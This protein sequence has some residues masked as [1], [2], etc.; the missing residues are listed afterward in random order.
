M[1][2]D[3]PAAILFDIN[4]DEVTVEDQ[5]L[6]TLPKGVGIGS[7]SPDP[8]ATY[9]EPAAGEKSSLSIDTSGN[10]V[11]RGQCLTDEDSFYDDFILPDIG[12]DW[13]VSQ[14]GGGAYVISSSILVLT[15][16][17]TSGD[18][19]RVTHEGDY[20][21]MRFSTDTKLGGKENG[22]VATFGFSNDDLPG[23]T[24]TQR[25]V[26]VVDG[27]NLNTV[28]FVTYSS[29]YQIQSTDIEIPNRG[30]VVEWHHY[31]I[32]VGAGYCSAYVDEVILATHKTHVPGPYDVMGY[33]AYVY[34]ESTIR[35]SQTLYMDNCM[36]RNHDVVEISGHF[37][38]DPLRVLLSGTP[39]IQITCPEHGTNVH[40]ELEETGRG[41]LFVS[42]AEATSV[43]SQIL[44]VM[45]KIEI[46]LAAMSGEE[47]QEGDI[48]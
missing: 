44:N 28:K 25:A 18:Y 29:D 8:S 4:G 3:S 12:D 45:K 10:L 21:P 35:L 48:E 32:E 43:L 9:Q 40:M 42:D 16:G 20:G 17:V 22:F 5:N 37:T 41:R 36:F 27:S 6:T 24:T 31:S 11:T 30:A 14:L 2:N 23:H 13:T 34:N 39:K 1:G 38:G 26:F 33:G 47:I 7:Y 46:H 15:A 19:I